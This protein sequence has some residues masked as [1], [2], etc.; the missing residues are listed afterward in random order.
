MIMINGLQLI[1]MPNGLHAFCATLILFAARCHFVNFGSYVAKNKKNYE[2][3]AYID[4]GATKW[5][6]FRKSSKG[7]GRSFSIQK[8]IL[9]I[10]HL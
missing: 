4:K 6:N 10:F 8:S 1:A 2:N 3:V 9:Q 5:I 7:W